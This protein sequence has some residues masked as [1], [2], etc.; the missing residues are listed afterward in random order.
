MI[1]KSLRND[2]L[3]EMFFDFSS[4]IVTPNLITYNT[5]MDFYA[6]TLQFQKAYEI[7]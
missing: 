6:M 7:F 3:M 2:G 5:L 1:D 4:L